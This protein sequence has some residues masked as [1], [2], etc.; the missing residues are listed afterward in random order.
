MRSLTLAT[1]AAAFS[2]LAAVPAGAQPTPRTVIER[3]VGAH[4][5]AERL[6]RARAE[7][8]RLQGKILPHGKDALVPFTAESTLQLPGRF[9]YAARINFPGDQA[10]ALVQIIDGDRVAVTIDGQPLERTAPALVELRETLH[11]QRVARLVPL[12]T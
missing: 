12:L 4:G 2:L 8:V 9:K 5:G 7:K 1:T 10:H 11:L 3:A 6:T